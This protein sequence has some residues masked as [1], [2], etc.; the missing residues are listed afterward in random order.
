VTDKVR[1]NE[2]DDTFEFARGQHCQDTLDN[3]L[4]VQSVHQNSASTSV[5]QCIVQVPSFNGT[6]QRVNYH[7]S[8]ARVS[9]RAE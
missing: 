4:S 2:N 3:V 6:L 1:K 7:F 9:S 8:L 5:S